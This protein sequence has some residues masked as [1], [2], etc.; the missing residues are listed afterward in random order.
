MPCSTIELP[1]AAPGERKFVTCDDRAVA[2]AIRWKRTSVNPRRSNSRQVGRRRTRRPILIPALILLVDTDRRPCQEDRGAPVGTGT[3]GGRGASFRGQGSPQHRQPKSR[4]RCAARCLRWTASGRPQRHPRSPP[5]CQGHHHTYPNQVLETEPEKHGAMFVVDP[6]QDVQILKPRV[7][8]TLRSARPAPP[9]PIR[10]SPSRAGLGIVGADRRVSG[11][12]RHELRGAE[13]GVRAGAGTARRL[14]SR[15]QPPASRCRRVRSGH[16]NSGNAADCRRGGT[17]ANTGMGAM[18]VAEF[19]DTSRDSVSGQG[20]GGHGFW[21]SFRT[22]ERSIH[23]GWASRQWRK[24]IPAHATGELVGLEAVRRTRDPNSAPTAKRRNARWSTLSSTI[25]TS[26]RE[27]GA[28]LSGSR[29]GRVPGLAR[30]S[31]QRRR[32]GPCINRCSAIH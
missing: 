8:A 10:R 30:I 26:G 31:G 3:P 23:R 4:R 25:S 15:C 9:S 16:L 6:L 20:V 1:P 24:R 19:V 18:T 12:R 7:Q 17:G 29:R 21:Q 2:E 28:S 27:S 32:V 22:T 13:A 14:R 11:A 5:A